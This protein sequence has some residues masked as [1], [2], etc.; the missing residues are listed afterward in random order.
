MGQ[1]HRGRRHL[2]TVSGWLRGRYGIVARGPTLAYRKAWVNAP[3]SWAAMKA[4]PDRMSTPAAS[5]GALST[6][7]ARASEACSGAPWPRGRCRSQPGSGTLPKVTAALGAGEPMP[8]IPARAGAACWLPW[9]AAC[10][11][12]MPTM[13]SSRPGETWDEVLLVEY[14]RATPSCMVQSPAYCRTTAAPPRC[15]A[16]TIVT[17]RHPARAIAG[18]RPAA[19]PADAPAGTP[20][21]APGRPARRRSSPPPWATGRSARPQNDGEGADAGRPLRRRAVVVAAPSAVVDAT[22]D[23]NTS[24]TAGPSQRYRPEPVSAGSTVATPSR[25]FNRPAHPAAL[26]GI[27][28]AAQM[29]DD[30][31][32]AS[33]SSA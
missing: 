15:D 4:E 18:A 5:P 7:H 26:A 3:P 16:A 9:A 25:L 6:L 21:H 8:R 29:R 13:P 17:A 11:V 22:T 1:V 28:Q 30:S 33:P 19:P 27:Q 12:V 2:F 23:R 24:Q 31:T 10:S 14:P 20:G 32:T